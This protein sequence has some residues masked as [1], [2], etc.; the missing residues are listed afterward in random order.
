[1][2]PS[3]S[4]S[5]LP[6]TLGPPKRPAARLLTSAIALAIITQGA[7]AHA[8]DLRKFDASYFETYAPRT[9]ADMIERLP[10]FQLTA[11]SDERGLGAGGA[12]VLINGQLIT[13]KGETPLEQLSRIPATNV[14][15]IEIVEGETLDI[16][17][18]DGPVADIVTRGGQTSGTWRWSPEFRPRTRSD[19]PYAPSG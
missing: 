17:G 1:M 10:G 16:P 18:L 19:C 4:A 7:P 9:A 8:Q 13:G 3:L 5:L 14:V 6:K 11:G 2:T 15:H 12:N